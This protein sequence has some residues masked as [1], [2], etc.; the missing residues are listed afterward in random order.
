MPRPARPWFRVYVEA[1]GDPKIRSLTPAQRWLWIAILAAA[2]Q[3]VVPGKLLLSRSQV[4]SSRDL[5]DFAGVDVRVVTN[6][7]P[8]LESLGMVRWEKRP[9][10]LVVCQWK[11][12]QYESDNT[13]ERTRKHRSREQG[14]NVPTSFPGTPPESES[15]NRDRDIHKSSSV[16]TVN[17]HPPDDDDDPFTRTVELVVEAKMRGREPT[18]GNGYR[19]TVKANTELE[20]GQ[21][22]RRMLD[23]GTEPEKVA[24]FVL[25]HGFGSDRT[26]INADALGTDVPWCDADCPECDGDAWIDTGH[27][28][29]PCPNRKVLR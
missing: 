3:S 16:S 12:R 20:D 8:L 5:A 1:F 11:E 7:L 28:L 13:T 21:L 6:A 24:L 23:D 25:G 17:G 27:G 4:M 26:T 10:C 22:I 29:A 9:R 19:R 14:R 15:E 2:R 18:N